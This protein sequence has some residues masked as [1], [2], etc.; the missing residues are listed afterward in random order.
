M[1]RRLKADL[2]PSCKQQIYCRMASSTSKNSKAP[3]MYCGEVAHEFA[4]WEY[5]GMFLGD[6]IY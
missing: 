3:V 5:V 6:K 1:Q 4:A 2:F